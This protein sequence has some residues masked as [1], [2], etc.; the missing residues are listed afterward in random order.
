MNRTS[1]AESARR[2]AR[3]TLVALHGSIGAPLASLQRPITF[4]PELVPLPLDMAEEKLA[5]APK[6]VLCVA[7]LVQGHLHVGT[8]STGRPLP[9]VEDML[10]MVRETFRE[11]PPDVAPNVPEVV[12]TSNRGASVDLTRA[13]YEQ[14][15]QDYHLPLTATHLGPSSAEDVTIAGMFIARV[16][17]PPENAW[18]EFRDS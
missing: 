10:E 5:A 2:L 8:W 13:E 14:W 12:V 9:M 7:V 1:T 17:P 15:I 16:K 6:P 4:L 3:A 18:I 11:P